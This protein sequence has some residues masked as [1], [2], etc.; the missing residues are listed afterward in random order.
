M[1]IQ[2]ESIFTAT[3]A[4][5]RRKVRPDSRAIGVQSVPVRKVRKSVAG[6]SLTGFFLALFFTS[7]WTETGMFAAD[8]IGESVPAYDQIFQRTNGWI[9]ADGDVAVTLTNGLTLWLFSDS[10]IGDVSGGRREHAS[11]IHHSFAWQHGTN[12]I[13][14]Q[15]EWFYAKSIAGKPGSLITPADGEGHFWIFDALMAKEKLFLFLAQIHQTDAK[16]AFGFQQ[17]GTWLGEVSNPLAPPT[18][19]HIEQ[20]KIPFAKY[21]AGENYSF[22]SASLVTN[23]FVYVYG[24]REQKQIGRGKKMILA[25][26]PETDLEN[27]PLWQFRTRVGWTTNVAA[28]ADLCDEMASE[29]SVSWLPAL[30]RFV[31]VCTEN[32]L[33]EKILVRTAIQ[34]WGPWSEATVVYHC[35]EAAWDKN[36]FC[37]AAKAHPMLADASNE[38]MITYAAN[39]FK[40]EQ[41]MSDARLYWPRFVRVRLSALIVHDTQ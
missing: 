14:A 40:F 36:I 39:S 33:S 38:L 24:T 35:P 23:G 32:G 2:Q 5:D 8:W 7:L 11:M 34:P 20:K 19:W 27:F 31:L 22:G 29:Y 1:R 3:T 4:A 13:S 28:A 10:F 25:R 26:A 30:R 6:N 21:G 16:D 41:L 17:I 15:V 18:E 12:P 9:G 37:Y